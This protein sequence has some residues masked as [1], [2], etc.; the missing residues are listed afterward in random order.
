M[1][2]NVFQPTLDKIL[3]CMNEV[4]TRHYSKGV[5]N[6]LI[7]S[8]FAECL[9]LQEAIRDKFKNMKVTI[10]EK[11]V[12][13]VLKGTVL[14]GQKPSYVQSRMMRFTYGIKLG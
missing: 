14:F 7:A 5:T 8:G 11:A 10:T 2:R 3:E 9:L 1:M 12:L 4:L 6:L 13:V